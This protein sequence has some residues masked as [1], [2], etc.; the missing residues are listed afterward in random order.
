MSAIEIVADAHGRVAIELHEP[1]AGVAAD[2]GEVSLSIS[3]DGDYAIAQCLVAR[4]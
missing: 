4:P 3:H 1:V 2:L